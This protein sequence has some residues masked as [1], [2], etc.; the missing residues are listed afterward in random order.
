MWTEDLDLL[1]CPRTGAALRLA[2]V[3]TRADDDEVL[4]GTLEAPDGTTYPIVN[5]IPRFVEDTGYNASWD[6][7]WT[8]LDAGAG[9]NYR[10]IDK[11]DPAYEIHDLFDRNGHGGQAH[12]QA[13]GG[14]AVD[15][16]CGI[17]QY[18][19]RLLREYEPRRLVSLDL[20]RGVDIFRRIVQERYPELRRRILFV[21]AASSRRRSRPASSTTSCP[22]AC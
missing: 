6:Y 13:Q 7:K 14:V 18:G 11:D 1:A 3:T 10:I 17:G 5:G 16:G 2:E 9:H 12:R 20:T 4:E 8:A 19:I 21:Q 22:S 15:L